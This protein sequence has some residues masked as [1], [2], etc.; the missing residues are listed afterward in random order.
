M[1]LGSTRRRFLVNENV[2]ESLTQDSYYWL[3]FLMA[4]GSVS[5]AGVISLV[6]ARKDR[7]HL[8]R[9]RE[10]LGSN[11]PIRDFL[12]AKKYETSAIVVISK[13]MSSS[14]SAYGIVPR[15]SHTAIASSSV[16]SNKDFWR[17]VFDGDGYIGI[18]TKNRLRLEL[19]CNE[20]L[21]QQFLDFLRANNI[22]T[23]ATVRPHKGHFRVVLLSGPAEQAAAL[24]YQNASVSLLR[25]SRYANG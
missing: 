10:F 19:T 15:K 20:A 13:I 6:L 8:E 18:D 7:S 1:P 17:G 24:L 11:L 3:G 22:P 2:F 4:D 5:D 12:I 25:K 16:S 9:F 21:G 14:L 23:K